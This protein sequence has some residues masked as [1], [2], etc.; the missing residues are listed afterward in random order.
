MAN[1]APTTGTTKGQQQ[2]T[3]PTS[4]PVLAVTYLPKT[5]EQQQ[6]RRHATSDVPLRQ[7]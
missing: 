1:V 5:Y 4:N 6:V 2:S 7:T 3:D